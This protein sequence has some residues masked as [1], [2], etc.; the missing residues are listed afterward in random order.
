[1]TTQ[2]SSEPV[3]PSSLQ[4]FP[5]H[6]PP[7]Q[8][9]AVH[10]S[11]L[12]LVGVLVRLRWHELSGRRGRLL[13]GVVALWLAGSAV[14]AYVAAGAAG[15]EM[16]AGFA[17][18][19]SV[20]WILAPLVGAG[21]SEIAAPER[22][23]AFPVPGRALRWATWAVSLSDVP[24]LLSVGALIGSAAAAGGVA[25]VTAALLMIVAGTGLG[26]LAAAW[27]GRLIERHGWIGS[28]LPAFLVAG[29]AVA[30]VH[31]DAVASAARVLPGGWVAEVY[32][33]AADGSLGRVGA[34][35]GALGVASAAA[36]FGVSKMPLS[37][38][39]AG[40]RTGTV[41]SRPWPR[42]GVALSVLARSMLRAPTTRLVIVGG[43]A[44]PGFLRFAAAAGGRDDVSVE[45][46]S[47]VLIAMGITVGVNVFSYCG[48]GLTL[49]VSS[50]AAART[51]VRSA[52]VLLAALC[53]VSACVSSTFSGILGIGAEMSLATLARLGAGAVAVA[54]LGVWWSLRHP[55][56][57]D[58]DSLRAKPAP[59]SSAVKFSALI[60]VTLLTVDAV[61]A[62][63][64][65]VGMVSGAVVFAVGVWRAGRSAD[66]TL[67][68]AAS[69]MRA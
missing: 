4:P 29:A 28:A 68:A 40:R 17:V 14:G 43:L 8:P 25:G 34:A 27:T 66:R 51:W 1:V 69:V 39:H 67:V 7:V 54:G 36:A 37:R 42:A 46:G 18:A 19:L 49:L 11:T 38:P 65:P 60:A 59:V 5:G 48:P 44:A 3:H 16:S 50:P 55:A 63:S 21:S 2:P 24:V 62:A 10:P 12:S 45:A 41:R 31:L 53:W 61:A 58:H 9:A 56:P 47:A 33:G 22:L 64:W 6:P 23:V 15:W 35:L 26:Q 30:A 52:A 13:L 57:T 32:R 20:G